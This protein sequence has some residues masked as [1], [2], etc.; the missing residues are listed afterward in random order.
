MSEFNDPSFG[1]TDEQFEDYADRAQRLIE[2]RV[3][4]LL[5]LH[6]PG[7]FDLS[8]AEFDAIVKY[9]V[10]VYTHAQVNKDEDALSLFGDIDL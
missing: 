6:L 10:L 3:K 8:Q 5:A 7:V 4:H 9:G 1:L 2:T